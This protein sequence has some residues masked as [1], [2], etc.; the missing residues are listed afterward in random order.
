MKEYVRT[1]KRAATRWVRRV[2]G[3]ATIKVALDIDR[4]Q[5]LMM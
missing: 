5:R 1:V 4:S 3:D 2:I